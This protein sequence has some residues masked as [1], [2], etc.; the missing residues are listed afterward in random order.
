MCSGFVYQVQNS[1]KISPWETKC[2]YLLTN[3]LKYVA[4]YISNILPLHPGKVITLPGACKHM[5]TYESIFHLS[6]L[7]MTEVGCNE[8]LLYK[9]IKIYITN[10]NSYMLWAFY[11][12]HINNTNIP[13]STRSFTF[14]WP[15]DVV[16]QS[17]G[18][19]VRQ[20]QHSQTAVSLYQSATGWG[21]SCH[22][23]TASTPPQRGQ[24]SCSRKRSLQFIQAPT[25]LDMYKNV[26][27]Q[28][29]PLTDSFVLN[30]F[31]V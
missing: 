10:T 30:Y 17:P 19:A 1:T 21:H 31:P 13:T 16:V 2:N 22:S 23:G 15:L 3:I 26:K 24:N 20:G 5:G 25:I 11:Q 7:T 14:H 6:V 29:H 9:I 28:T 27:W 12:L 4:A 18:P 8:R